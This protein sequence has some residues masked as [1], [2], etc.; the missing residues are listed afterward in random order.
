MAPARSDQWMS[1]QLDKTSNGWAA[2][3]R[4]NMVHIYT[5]YVYVHLVGL[6]GGTFLIKSKSYDSKSK[7]WMFMHIVNLIEH[8]EGETIKAQ[9]DKHL[10]WQSKKQL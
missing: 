6:V 1:G 10:K 5:A 3:W 2:S 7:E 9:K 8:H 4:D